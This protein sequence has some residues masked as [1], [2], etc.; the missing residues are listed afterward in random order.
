V[1]DRGAYCDT[2]D[3]PLLGNVSSIF[4]WEG[5]YRCIIWG[6]AYAAVLAICPR[7]PEPCA[8]AWAG[9]AAAAAGACVVAGRV[10]CW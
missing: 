3:G 4:S 2:A 9:G 1:A 7:R 5:G 10:C 8:G 6:E